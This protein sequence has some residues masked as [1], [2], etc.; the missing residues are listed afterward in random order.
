MARPIASFAAALLMAAPRFAHDIRVIDEDTFE[1]DRQSFMWG[2]D[3]LELEQTCVAEDGSGIHIGAIAPDTLADLL[4]VLKECEVMTV[5]EAGQT[6][7][8][9]ALD[10]ATDV[11]WHLVASGLAFDLLQVSGGTYIDAEVVAYEGQF[12]HWRY[13]C[14]PPWE[15]RDR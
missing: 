12:G 11:A 3:A 1:L 7:G 14:L 2:V 8:W 9:C 15:W 5:D 4:G 10:D 6:F 13:C